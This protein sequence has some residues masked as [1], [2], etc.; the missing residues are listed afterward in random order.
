MR[1]WLSVLLFLALTGN[2]LAAAWHTPKRGSKDRS[3]IMNAIRPG[4]EK[5][6]NAP[7]E[8]VIRELRVLDDWA[9]AQVVPQRPGGG[10]IFTPPP[11]AP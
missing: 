7:I 6:L 1:Y 3:E 8:F 2:G 9:F 10:P 11:P 5:R 4:V